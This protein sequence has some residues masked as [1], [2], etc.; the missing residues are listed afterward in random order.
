MGRM[1]RPL[2]AEG[3]RRATIGG[4]TSSLDAL[5]TRYRFNE[6]LLQM[7]S[8]GFS[9]AMWTHVPEGG[10]NTAH[11]ILG[12]VTFARRGA[13]RMAGA[14]LPVE[15]WEEAFNMGATPGTGEDYP[16]VSELVALFSSAGD[17]MTEHFGAMTE[18]AANAP[19]PREFPDGSKTV[20]DAMH[21]MYFH[22]A[23]HL[24]QIGYI[25]RL[26]GLPGF[27]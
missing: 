17:R 18:D 10:G 13:L 26:E 21:F 19:S 12:H 20:A 4:M 11:W 8:G 5:A 7:A 3:V 14:E 22:E 1:I 16:P 6:G 2:R 23:Y 24:G 25:R 27:I 9:E 15:A